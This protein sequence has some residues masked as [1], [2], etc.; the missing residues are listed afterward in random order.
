[1]KKPF[2][3]IAPPMPDE[4]LENEPS[5]EELMPQDGLL[6]QH[7]ADN[8][9]SLRTLLQDL[10]EERLQFRYAPGKWDIRE[11]VLHLMD[12][13][14][15]FAYRAL[16]FARNDKTILPGYDHLA[17]TAIAHPANRSIEDLL[18]EYATIRSATLSLF[19]SLDDEALLRRGTANGSRASVRALAYYIGGHELHHRGILQRDYLSVAIT[20]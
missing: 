17:W 14:R 16:S 7:M 11:M 8:F 20:P 10:P 1:M 5:L 3:H 13:E 4:Y 6:L 15:V 2:R 12:S 18:E 9:A 19:N